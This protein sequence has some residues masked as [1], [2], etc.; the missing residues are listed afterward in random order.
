MNNAET[1]RSNTAVAEARA[2][3]FCPHCQQ[4]IDMRNVDQLMYHMAPE[5]KPEP[6][7]NQR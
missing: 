6:R 3:T 1:E 4:A 5:H 7:H 2:V